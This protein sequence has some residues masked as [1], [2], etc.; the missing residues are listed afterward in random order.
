MLF[1]EQ[2]Q[3]LTLT[4]ENLEAIPKQMPQSYY[5][6]RTFRNFTDFKLSH[7]FNVDVHL[8]LGSLRLVDM[9][10]VADVL[11]VHPEGL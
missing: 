4:N 9:G 11:G 1:I 7:W 2:H 6:I 3:K 5:A 10:S 8:S